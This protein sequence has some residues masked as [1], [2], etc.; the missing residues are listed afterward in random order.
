MSAH[1]RDLYSHASDELLVVLWAEKKEKEKEK[2]VRKAIP[3]AVETIVTS[4]LRGGHLMRSHEYKGNNVKIKKEKS[5]PSRITRIHARSFNQETKEEEKGKK[6][7]LETRVEH[8]HH[9]V[10]PIHRRNPRLQNALFMPQN[11]QL[12]SYLSLLPI[13]LLQ[14]LRHQCR[15]LLTKLR[16]LRT[17]TVSGTSHLFCVGVHGIHHE[18]AGSAEELASGGVAGAHTFWVGLLQHETWVECRLEAV[19]G[20]QQ[21]RCKEAYQPYSQSLSCVISEA[22]LQEV[23][24]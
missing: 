24:R 10:P 21:V 1:G 14:E 3:M 6:E 2:S 20:A 17:I 8:P 18:G 11:Q 22:I 23:R 4:D 7:N 19:E 16:Y 5:L 13:L 9:P 12:R 15:E